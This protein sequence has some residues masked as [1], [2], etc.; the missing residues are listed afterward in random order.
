VNFA[1]VLWAE[2]VRV[3]ERSGGGPQAEATLSRGLQE[4]ST[5]GLLWS[6]SIWAEPRP[7]RKSRLVDALK[8]SADNLVIISGRA[9]GTNS[10]LGDSWVWRLKFERQHGTAVSHLNPIYVCPS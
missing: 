9:V 2:A 8:K 4:C 7:T 6:M 5:S 3:E 10:N 1:N